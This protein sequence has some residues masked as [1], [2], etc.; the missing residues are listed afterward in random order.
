MRQL[1]TV[2]AA[3]TV[4]GVMAAC[5]TPGGTGGTI[6][7]PTWTLSSQASG[8]SL[9]DIPDGVAADAT[10]TGGMIA[11]SAG[12]NVFHG[13]AAISGATIEVGL[14]GTTAMAC[15]PPASDVET[16]YLA[17][18]ADAATFTATADALTIYDSSGA[19]LLVYAAGPANPLE[20]EWDVTGVNNG[21]EAVTSPIVGTE[22]TATFTA[23]GVSGNSGCNTY[24]GGYTLDGDQVTIGP[25]ASTMMACEQA[26]MDQ[27]TQF[28]TALQTPGLTVEVSGGTVTL[29]DGNGATQVVLAPK[30]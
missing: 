13:P 21:K 6:E 3:V 20:G 1:V 15:Q 5:S 23:D 26:I 27:E 9:A 29:R 7:G 22:L 11:G 30:A 18:L 2:I 19:T 10:F 4:I 12:C 14:L 24:T 28:L 16:A 17:N 8:G 25:L